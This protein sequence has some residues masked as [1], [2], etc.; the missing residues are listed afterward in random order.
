MYMHP[1]C[2]EG[3]NTRFSWLEVKIGMHR[4][5]EVFRGYPQY[6]MA[7]RKSVSSRIVALLDFRTPPV[8]KSMLNTTCKRQYE[9]NPAWLLCL[10][11][12]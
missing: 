8:L 11:G 6:M 1:N 5:A 7:N 4:N 10:S 3:Q 12:I 9:E 2:S